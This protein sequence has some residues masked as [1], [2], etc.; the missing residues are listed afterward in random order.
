[1]GDEGCYG[2]ARRERL[3]ARF[4]ALAVPWWEALPGLVERLSARWG[5]RVGEPVGRG[6]TSL[7]LLCTRPDGRSAVLKLTPDPALAVD[8]ARALRRWEASRRVPAVWEAD[9]AAGALLLEALPDT[10]PLADAA[11]TPAV[12]EAAELIAALHAAGAPAGAPPLL[13][14]VDFVF[15]LW[16]ARLPPAVPAELLRRGHALARE[17]AADPGVPRVLLHGDLHPANVLDGGPGRGLVAIDPR[18]C[19]GD[20]LFDAVDW[21]LWRLSGD[22]EARLA[23][24]APGAVERLRAW[25]AAFAAMIAAWRVNRG[26]ADVGRLLDLAA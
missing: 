20:P 23:V 5:L 24:L 22:L 2:A 15:P 14:R 4:G 10:T 17:L 1:M 6:S 8:E 16:E 3:I 11:R 7:V 13:E 18:P 26:D 19:A 12:E 25:C 21:A 9:A